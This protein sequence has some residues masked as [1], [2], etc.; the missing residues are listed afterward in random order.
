M[1][2]TILNETYYYENL[3]LHGYLL[4]SLLATLCLAGIGLSSLASKL[5]ANVRLPV[6]IAAGLI[7]IGLPGYVNWGEASLAGNSQARRYAT[8]IVDECSEGALLITSSY[9]SY[10]TIQALQKAYGYRTDLEVVNVHLF[11]Q[12]WYRDELINRFSLERTLVDVRDIDQYYASL[13]NGRIKRSEIFIEYDDMSAGLKNYL[14]PSG[15][16]MRYDVEPFSLKKYGGLDS[17][18]ADIQK[19]DNFLLL[20]TDYEL[21]MSMIWSLDNRARFYNAMGEKEIADKYSAAIELAVEN[22]DKNK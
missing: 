9:N 1:L 14:W 20:G 5:P 10:F 19:F 8:A 6:I 16:W 17:V 15:L 21:L 22:Y 3:D 4:F 2:S 13:I 11:G 18:D 7:S 12:K